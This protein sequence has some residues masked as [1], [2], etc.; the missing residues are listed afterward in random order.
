MIL[1]FDDTTERRARPYYLQSNRLVVPIKNIGSGPALNISLNVTPVKAEGQQSAPWDGK[2]YT[3][4]VLGLGVGEAIPAI[5]PIPGL[6]GVP[7][8]L[9]RVMYSDVAEKA[10]V[11]SSKYF[12]LGGGSYAHVSI[13]PHTEYQY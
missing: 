5:V 10:W 8:F 9:L 7:S 13:V 1:M 4:V 11:T 6:G 12:D 3:I 2:D